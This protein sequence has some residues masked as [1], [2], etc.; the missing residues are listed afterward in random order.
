[1]AEEEATEFKTTADE[2]QAFLNSER[3]YVENGLRVGFETFLNRLEVHN[4]LNHSLISDEDITKIFSNYRTIYTANS[5]LFDD[6]MLLRLEGKE[7][8]RDNLG[9]FMVD[10]I[11]YFRIY[12]DYIVKKQAAIT[13]LD[14]LKKSNK[15][16]RQFLKINET[17]AGRKLKSF[18]EEPAGR[19]PQYLQHLAGVYVAF[20]HE[21]NRDSEAASMLLQAIVDI[22][23]VTDEIAVKCRDLKARILVGALQEDVFKNKIQL[24]AAHRYCISHASMSMVI[25]DKVKTH[26]FVLCNDILVIAT[27]ATAFKSGQLIVVY[28]LIGLRIARDPK[29]PESLNKD[30][31]DDEK[32]KYRFALVPQNKNF[33][34]SDTSNSVI[35]SVIIMCDSEKQLEKWIETIE[36]TVDEEEHN[37][38][39]CNPVDLE[40]RLRKQKTSKEG[41]AETITITDP[42][43]IKE[44]EQWK[45]AKAMGSPLKK[46]RSVRRATNEPAADDEKSDAPKLAPQSSGNAPPPKGTSPRPPSGAHS[47][48]PKKAPPTRH[49][50]SKPPSKPSKPPNKPPPRRATVNPTSHRRQQSGPP[51]KPPSG[52]TGAPPS[53]P[54]T[55]FP[56]KKAPKTVALKENQQDDSDVIK[57]SQT[58]P[59]SSSAPTHKPQGSRANMLASIHSFKSSNLKTVS[60]EQLKK[61]AAAKP[62]NVNNLLQ[63]TLANYRQFVMDDDD[64]DQSDADWDD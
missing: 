6:M 33:S 60:A 50:I 59:T 23:A 16:F 61:E 26:K 54:P 46:I 25:S 42:E 11:P 55:A 48:P 53:K 34:P 9:K 56:P 7:K 52:S 1:M 4:K 24:L 12:T 49:S 41:E 36:D 62:S 44:I 8:L 32:L 64:S 2:A 13:H 27:L 45:Q 3:E 10:F 18:L 37:L 5:K 29:L 58:V 38:K 35:G 19:L 30:H 57:R 15:K 51:T 40:K 21:A 31:A 63:S 47:G 43:K 17:C 22:K 28:P 20:E 39:P 14:K